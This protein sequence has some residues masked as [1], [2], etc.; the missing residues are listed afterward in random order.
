MATTINLDG[1]PLYD[2]RCDK[3]DYL[4]AAGCG[5]LAGII[6]IF[7]VGSPADSKLQTWTDA[8]VDGA[9]RTFAKACGWT[10]KPGNEFNTASAIGYL[11]NGSATSRKDGFYGFKVTYDQ[12]HS[13]DVSGMFT[14]SAANHHLKSLAHS[15]DI[16]GLFFSVLN[17]FTSTST[18]I[19]DG[20][21][22]TIDTETFE[23]NG[24]TFPAKLFC[25]VANWVGH[26]MSDVA[27]SSGSRGNGGRGAGVAI[28]FY[29]LFQFC[30][31]GQFQIGNDRQTLATLAIRVFQEGYDARFGITMAIPV[32]LCNL[33]IKL[34]WAIKQR[35]YHKRDLRDCIPSNQH[36]DLRVML[37][38]GNGTLCVMDGADAALRSNG[39]WIS[40]FARLNIIAWFKFITLV[41]KEVCIR[42]GIA[43]PL[44]KELAA[45]MRVRAA[46]YAYL[47]ELEK[48]D[49][50]RFRQ[51]TESYNI[52]VRQIMLVETDS[53]LNNAL[54]RCY[55]E[56]GI[57]LP[58]KGS[59][60]EAMRDKST[61]LVFG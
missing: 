18:F 48:I 59:F 46:I 38:I 10:P 14:M 28:P 13:G 24:E 43:M 9:V 23:L 32:L 19:S 1:R 26:I 8:Q 22:I 35:F 27:G 39:N 7:L 61:P 56:L 34:I 60:D 12:R 36:P 16:I 37:L 4:I 57:S 6:D 47:E 21:L 44:Q 2:D 45:F 20:K 41:L 3:Y 15:P 49:I 54:H 11:E 50:Q 55:Q 40:F 25:G 30:E 58:W 5:A 29:E 42:V 31:F 52:W 51:E 33:S 53:Q 17:Q